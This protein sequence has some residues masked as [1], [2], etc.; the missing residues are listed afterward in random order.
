[1]MKHLRLLPAVMAVGALLLG[2]KAVGL[3][4][5]AEAQTQIATAPR[6]AVVKAT[7]D[8]DA[9]SSSSEVDVLTSL[10][11]RRAELETRAREL[12]TQQELIVAAEKRVDDKIASLKSLQSQ[13]QVLLVQRDAAQQ[14]QID[15]LV[16]TYSQMKPRD[17]A[18]IFNSLE[19]NV[20]VPVAG[21]MKPDVL[22]AILG[23]MDSQ[24]AQKLTV[25]LADR[26]KLPDPPPPAPPA[27]PTALQTA[28]TQPPAVPAPGTKP[29]E[30]A[31]AAIPAATPAVA[32]AAAAPAAAK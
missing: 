25:K 19:E 1:M 26:L 13:I 11:R 16:K 4:H 17:A 8:E 5:V 6:A 9:E 18:R 12:Q 22:A 2:V 24:N 20:L 10:S 14:K 29:S 21:Q 31:P 28:M 7:V 15:A 32:P 3:V 27:P 23:L 30:A